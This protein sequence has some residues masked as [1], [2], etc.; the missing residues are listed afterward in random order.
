MARFVILKH[1]AEDTHFDLMF[2]RGGVLRTF[3]SEAEP[4]GREPALEP[5]FDH[6]LKVLDFEGALENAPGRVERWDG[7][8]FE[9]LEWR[10]DVIKIDCNGRRW[11][12]P[13]LLERL[14]EN[15][16]SAKIQPRA[17]RRRPR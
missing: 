15:R 13:Y 4:S 11:A 2:E 6:P 17:K 3:R 16:W 12:S 1:I 9:A 7:G 10:R 5:S 8:T 14:N